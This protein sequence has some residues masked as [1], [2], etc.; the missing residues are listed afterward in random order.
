MPFPVL[1]WSE[2]FFFFLHFLLLLSPSGQS[3]AGHVWTMNVLL[4]G[5]T[6]NRRGEICSVRCLRSDKALLYMTFTAL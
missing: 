6:H 2:D 4:L 1:K 3:L 5:G